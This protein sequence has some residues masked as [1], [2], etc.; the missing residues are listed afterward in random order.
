MEKQDRCFAQVVQGGEIEH[1]AAIPNNATQGILRPHSFVEG[2]TTA[3]TKPTNNYPS[4]QPRIAVL[5]QL[6]P[7]LELFFYVP[8]Y[9]SCTLI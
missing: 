4:S 3:L 8:L 9:Y 1:S 6:A 2:Q 7:I 5:L